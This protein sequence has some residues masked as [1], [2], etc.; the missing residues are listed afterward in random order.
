MVAAV[1]PLTGVVII[2]FIL[3]QIYCRYF[4]SKDTRLVDNL[5]GAFVPTLT[6]AVLTGPPPPPLSL[7]T[8]F[9]KGNI[10][11]FIFIIYEILYFYFF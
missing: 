4:K 11:N 8:S 6:I 9:E 10:N 5:R 3:Y 7:S 1:L 2:I